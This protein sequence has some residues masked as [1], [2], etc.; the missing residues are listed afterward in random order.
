MKKLE[1]RQIIFIMLGVMLSVLLSSLDSTIVGTAMPKIINELYGMEH[2]TWPFTAYM[3]CSTIAIPIFGKIA[4]IYGR[5]PIWFIGAT[6][7][8]VST[9][10]CGLSQTM[11][12][13]IIFRG[14]Q[15]LGGGIL[16]SNSF[17]IVGQ[18]FSPQERGKYMGMVTAVF[19]L[20]SVIGPALGGYITDNLNWRWVFYVNLPVGI[21]AMGVMFFAL[22]NYVDKSV[23]KIVDYLGATL[24]TLALVPMLLAFT[25]GGRDYAWMSFQII[26]MLL[27]SVVMLIIFVIVER[28]AEEPILS[29][30]FFKNK[31]YNISVLASFLTNAAM[32]GAITFIPLFVQG[33]M[34]TSATNSGM[35]TTPMTLGLVVT[36]IIAGQLISKTGKYKTMGIVG[37]VIS[38]VG[39]L[40]MTFM[41]TE[42][43]SSEI[44]RNMV[45]LGAGLGLTL[46]IFNVI[47]Q[48]E[49]EV[50]ELGSVTA[51]VQF[52]RNIGGTISSAVLGTVMMNS[53]N[54]GFNKLDL[55]KVPNPMKSIFSNPQLFTNADS[56][57]KVREKIPAQVMG[58]FD[59]VMV[60]IKDVISISIHK[61]FIISIFILIA[62]IITTLLIKEKP[63]KSQEK[64]LE[65]AA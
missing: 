34:G 4:D 3:L 26:G 16:M 38:L 28:K 55:S 9:A 11:L 18:I 27:F 21:L 51:S 50:R 58:I 39:V 32:F 1:K 44:V 13:L 10:L 7:F 41:N 14:I 12:Q 24:L 61:V 37:F 25:W 31:T 56:I 45:I 65:E 23:K 48:N 54:D 35:I 19:G 40:L 30:K 60:Q 5:K 6:I 63:L 53:M 42:S 46:P 47:I 8:L 29:P 22:P 49:F 20:S 15:G 17:A 64:F 2:Y 43:T 33:V 36:S 57:N 59:S 52:F 62:A